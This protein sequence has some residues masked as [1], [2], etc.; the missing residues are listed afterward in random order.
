VSGTL[1]CCV[2]SEGKGEKDLSV[3]R[4]RRRMI[5]WSGLKEKEVFLKLESTVQWIL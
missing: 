2:L 3:R 4:K 1:L 5:L